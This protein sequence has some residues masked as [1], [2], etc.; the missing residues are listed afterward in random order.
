MS[1]HRLIAGSLVALGLALGAAPGALAE[2]AHSHDAAGAAELVLDHGAKWQTDEALRTGMAGLRDDVAAALPQIHDGAF[3]PAQYAELA[4]K[5]DGRIQYIVENCK[6]S[7]E[8]DEQLH[9]VLVE[10]MDGAEAMKGGTEQM[11]GAVRIVEA[12][13]LYPD[14]F[15]HPSWQPLGH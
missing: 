7:P 5:I 1:M 4:G 10:I 8:A 12:L 14:Y 9:V 6:L 3:T 11:Q 2:D 13:N 15:D